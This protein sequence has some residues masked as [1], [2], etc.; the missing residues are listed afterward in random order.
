M[1]LGDI[2][3]I[4]PLSFTNR[5]LKWLGDFD[6]FRRFV[7]DILNIKGE[8]KVPRGSCRQLKTQDITIRWY[9]N[10][11]VLL[12]GTMK[13][14]YI[15]ILKK[16][17][18]ISPDGECNLGVDD[19]VDIPPTHKPSLQNINYF[20]VSANLSIVELLDYDAFQSDF[21]ISLNDVASI[22]GSG[23][24]TKET[25]VCVQG[26][27][28]DD[29]VKRLDVLSNEFE[30]YRAE[31]TIVMNELVDACEIRNSQMRDKQLVQENDS[32][33]KANRA[34]ESDLHKLESLLSETSS[35]L[36]AAESEK[37]SLMA[38]IRLLNE[39]CAN[40]VNVVEKKDRSQSAQLKNSWDMAQTRNGNHTASNEISLNNQYSCLSIEDDDKNETNVAAEQQLIDHN[41]ILNI[42][43]NDDQPCIKSKSNSNEPSSSNLHE[44]SSQVERR[45]E[46]IDGK[47]KKNQ[48]QKDLNSNNNEISQDKNVQ[49]PD[50]TNKGNKYRQ[51]DRKTVVI[52]GDS[53]VKYVQGRN[54]STKVRS[55]VKSFP[56][57]RVDHMFHYMKPS[58]ELKPD[59]IILHVGTNDLKNSS[60]DYIAQRIVDLGHSIVGESPTTK[61][62]ISSL[63]VR[64]DNNLLNDKAI[65]V[66]SYLS[67]Y[68]RQ[69]DWPILSNSNIT[70]SHLNASGLHLNI[71]GTNILSSNLSKHINI[72]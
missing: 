31:T 27:L 34:L 4:N 71:K 38:V 37:A 42:E 35:K 33:K 8:W 26:K 72:R 5:K 17:A 7:E 39:D 53:I 13:D 9:E 56:G 64:T 47:K 28:L 60:P 69:Y 43:D 48:R 51:K 36:L 58:L 2:T 12:D 70:T 66:N 16:I 65:Q 59:E 1:S 44:R 11:S 20:M 62:T 3:K 23:L 15:G 32:L 52:L 6:S 21:P 10:R 24:S 40:P 22:S 55:V 29:V 45:V 41:E 30:K 61:V 63:T 68:A 25:P 57:A 19:F 14:E 50:E 67:T 49:P 18:T 54:L 46:K